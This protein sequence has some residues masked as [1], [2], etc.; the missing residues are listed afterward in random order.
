MAIF[1]KT[2]LHSFKQKFGSMVYCSAPTII[3]KSIE[4]GL[5]GN[6]SSIDPIKNFAL[7]VLTAF[8]LFFANFG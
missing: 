2:F 7:P 8:L 1:F 4:F 6:F 3:I 5:N